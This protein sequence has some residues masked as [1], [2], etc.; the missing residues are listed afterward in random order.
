MAVPGPVRIAAVAMPDPVFGERVCLYA[1]LVPGAQLT[2][3]E[4]VVHMEK[5]GSSK[6]SLPERLVVVPELPRSSG[7]KIAKQ[8]LRE[9]IAQ[10]LQTEAR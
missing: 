5:N 10:R 6:E 1:E 2:L 4:L 9:D 8:A 3:A 7:G